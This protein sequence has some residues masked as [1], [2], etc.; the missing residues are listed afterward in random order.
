MEYWY[1]IINTFYLDARY[2]VVSNL[3]SDLKPAYLDAI[4]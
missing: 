4:L 3:P 2:S 1:D